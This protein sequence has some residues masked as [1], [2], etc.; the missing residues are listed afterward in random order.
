MKRFVRSYGVSWL[1]AVALISWGAASRCGSGRA[2]GNGGFMPGGSVPISQGPPLLSPQSSPQGGSTTSQVQEAVVLG[3]NFNGKVAAWTTTLLV[4]LLGTGFCYKLCSDLI[5][6]VLRRM[7]LVDAYH[8][9]MARVAGAAIAVPLASVGLMKYGPFVWY[10][11]YIL[12]AGER[13]SPLLARSILHDIQVY[14]QHLDTVKSVEKELREAIAQIN[15]L[16]GVGKRTMQPQ[17]VP[18]ARIDP[19][20]LAHIE[21]LIAHNEAEIQ[22]IVATLQLY[23]PKEEIAQCMYA[24]NRGQKAPV[25]TIAP[26][27]L[28]Q[29]QAIVDRLKL[30]TTDLGDDAAALNLLIHELIE[31]WQNYTYGLAKSIRV[32]LRFCNE[33][34]MLEQFVVNWL[35]RPLLCV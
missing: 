9:A 17:S 29:A 22:E 8:D 2:F 15:A 4:A 23:L 20:I 10:G 30:L 14:V 13:V 27:L 16:V 11:T 28:E 6:G 33:V 3:Q 24:L 18:R 7:P 5:D 19:A 32:D 26:E 34:H 1:L 12:Y 21:E 31:Y 25:Y 35:D